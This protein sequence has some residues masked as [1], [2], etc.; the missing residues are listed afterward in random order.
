MTPTSLLPKAADQHGWT[1]EQLVAEI[2][3]TS[4]VKSDE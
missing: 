4:G 3:S 1:F 2:L